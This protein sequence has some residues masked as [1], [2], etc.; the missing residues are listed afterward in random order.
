MKPIILTLFV[1]VASSQETSTAASDASSKTVT[2]GY[3]ST[4]RM[5]Q[6]PIQQ[7][8]CGRI[9]KALVCM[10]KPTA[11]EG[12]AANMSNETSFSFSPN[13]EKALRKY[14]A[15]EKK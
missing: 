11:S 4:A 15:Q 10:G 12:A 13:L 14:F 1:A 9:G 2:S 6:Q 3:V 8:E 5:W 7:Y